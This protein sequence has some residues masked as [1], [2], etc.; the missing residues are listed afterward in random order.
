MMRSKYRLRITG[1]NPKS[2]LRFLYKLNIEMYSISYDLSS[3]TIVVDEENYQKILKLKT[4]YQIEIISRYGLAKYVYLFK[5]Y[6]LFFLIVLVGYFI[7]VLLSHLIFEVEVVHS[8]QEIRELV[9]EELKNEGISRLKWKVSFARQEKIADNILKKHKDKIEWLEIENVGTKYI[10][11]VEERKLNEEQEEKQPQDIVAKKDGMILKIEATSGTVVKKKNDYVK[12]GDIIITGVTKNQDTLMKLVP[13]EGVVY[14]ETWYRSTV[15]M[16]LQYHESFLTGEKKTVL[17]ISF[18]NRKFSLFD[19]HPFKTSKDDIDYIIKNPLIPFSIQKTVKQ[20]T[21]VIDEIYT[22]EEATIKA[23]ELAKEK[24]QKRLG[25]NDEIISEKTL[26]ITE[27]ESKIIVEI[28]FKVKE[29]ITATQKIE[30]DKV[31]TGEE[32][33]E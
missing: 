9:L 11:K 8:N 20:E 18:L 28:F 31:Q 30:I 26:K 14:A 1:K 17:Q 4:S 19:F 6:F 33:Q 16:P 32:K 12:Q 5:K 3:S 13:A 22:R 10:V 2:F 29:D 25:V 7:L 21:R 23:I 15:E 27:K 24:L